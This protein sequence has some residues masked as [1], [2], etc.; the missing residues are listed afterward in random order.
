M[1][2]TLLRRILMTGAACATMTLGVSAAVHAQPNYDDNSYAADQ[3]PAVGEITVRPTFR[4]ERTYDGADIVVARATR[5]VDV[6]DLDLSTG[7]GQ[8]MAY[9]RVRNAA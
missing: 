5:V 1:S 6:S 9:R 4:S 8:H 2:L 7:W 3:A